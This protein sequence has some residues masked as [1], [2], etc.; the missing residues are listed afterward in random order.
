MDQTDYRTKEQLRRQ[1]EQL[2]AE[3]QRLSVDAVTGVAGRGVFDRALQVEHARSSRTRRQLGV[4]MLDIDHF[5]RVN[6]QHGHAIGDQ[7]LRSVAQAAALHVRASDTFARYGGEEFVAL[8]DGT[9]RTGLIALAERIRHSVAA[10]RYP[11]PQVTISIGVAFIETDEPAEDGIKRAD[12]ALYQ[13]KDA[14]R[15]QVKFQS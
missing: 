6:D 12:L 7:V 13:A 1:V 11:L 10:D 2:R 4:M 15:N 5:K 9:T 14:G 8:I 3:V